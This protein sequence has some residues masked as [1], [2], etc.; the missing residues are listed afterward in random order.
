MASIAVVKDVVAGGE[1]TFG[2]SG[3]DVERCVFVVAWVFGWVGNEY[4]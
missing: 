3:V 4:P 1:P 2:F